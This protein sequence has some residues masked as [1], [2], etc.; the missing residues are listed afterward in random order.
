MNTM[1][2]RAETN[3][4]HKVFAQCEDKRILAFLDNPTG[5]TAR[6]AL[7]AMEHNRV[8][9]PLMRNILQFVIDFEE[10]DYSYGFIGTHD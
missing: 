4:I 7:D 6:R 2:S 8:V 10:F 5:L 1:I 3:V 9:N